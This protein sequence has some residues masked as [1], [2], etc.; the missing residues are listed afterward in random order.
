MKKISIAIGIF[1]SLLTIGT[2]IMLNTQANSNEEKIHINGKQVEKEHFDDLSQRTFE[3]AQI[4]EVGLKDSNAQLSRIENDV[5]HFPKRIIYLDSLSNNSNNNK[6]IELFV[7]DILQSTK[8][9]SVIKKNETF[10]I[11]VYSKEDK[12]IE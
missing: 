7:E 12:S 3:L 4:I 8:A 5:N 6:E 11:I 9:Q 1:L 10:E 2:L